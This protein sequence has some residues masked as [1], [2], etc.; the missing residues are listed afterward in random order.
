MI[1]AYP[2]FGFLTEGNDFIKN[3]VNIRKSDFKLFKVNISKEPF[4]EIYLAVF[5]LKGHVRRG[6]EREA[7]ADCQPD[8][9]CPKAIQ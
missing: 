7:E 3:I 6:R 4:F 2:A 5:Y 8:N 9:A 1:S